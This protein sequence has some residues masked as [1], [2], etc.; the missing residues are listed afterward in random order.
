MSEAHF[1]LGR[2]VRIESKEELGCDSGWAQKVSQYCRHGT[3]Q[4]D[5]FSNGVHLPLI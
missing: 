4:K 1:Q 3:A 5:L 2:K